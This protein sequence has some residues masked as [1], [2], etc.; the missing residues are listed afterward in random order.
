MPEDQLRKELD[1]VYNSLSWRV[2]APLRL[3]SFWVKWVVRILRSPKQA[4]KA[5]IHWGI[6]QAWLVT[7][8]RKFFTYFPGLKNRLRRFALNPLVSVTPTIAIPVSAKHETTELV[9][10]NLISSQEGVSS[11]LDKISL[12]SQVIFFELQAAIKNKK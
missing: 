10:S 3:L 1:A 11:E 7:I 12:A 2:T 5:L 6:R 4:F 8:A 9:E